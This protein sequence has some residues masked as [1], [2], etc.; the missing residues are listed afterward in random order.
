MT[1][2]EITAAASEYSIVSLVFLVMMGGC[3]FGM[4]LGY[5]WYWIVAA[6]VLFLFSIGCPGSGMLL[7]ALAVTVRRYAPRGLAWLEKLDIGRRSDRRADAYSGDRSGSRYR[8]TASG[9]GGSASKGDNRYSYDDL[10]GDRAQQEKP[11]APEVRKGPTPESI[12]GLGSAFSMKDLDKARRRLAKKFHPDLHRSASA[13]KQQ[14]MAE[15]MRAVNSAYEALK[16]QA[17]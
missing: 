7:T 4:A 12:L 2:A 13:K 5:P 1:G 16:A 11:L 17:A 15:R 3:A 8:D 6:S 14:Y 9:F 10:F